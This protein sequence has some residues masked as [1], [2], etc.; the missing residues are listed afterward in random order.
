MLPANEQQRPPRSESTLHS[1]EVTGMD[2]AAILVAAGPGTRL[3]MGTPKAFVEVA[4][5]PLLVRAGRV[6]AEVDSIASVVVVVPPD[7]CDQATRL[8]ATAGPW[9]TSFEVVAGGDQRQDSVRAGLAALTPA[10]LV[11][12][13]D[14][15]RPFVATNTIHDV[16]AAANAHG[17]AIAALPANDTAKEVDASRRIMRTP[18]RDYV[19]LAQ[20]PQ[21]FRWG[22][23]QA[24]HERAQA[25]GFVGTD[26]SVLVE[27]LGVPVYVV[28]GTA[29]NRKIT[30]PD[31]L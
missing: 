16:I 10:A 17:A 14:A 24:A 21:V 22:L 27:R 29:E 4:E 19:W 12:I 6:L 25:D 15:A 13:H 28:R 18:K 26:D 11:L 5:V 20:T 9:R 30:T 31:D 1:A 7:R 8:L 23:I 3:R 2:T